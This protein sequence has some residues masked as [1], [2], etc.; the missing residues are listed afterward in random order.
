MTSVR[1][2]AECSRIGTVFRIVRTAPGR[3]F[4]AVILIGLFFP[5]FPGI[6]QLA[7]DSWRRVLRSTRRRTDALIV[8]LAFLAFLIRELVFTA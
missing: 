2:T 7:G 5:R 4:H 3:P 1:V 6:A 8:L